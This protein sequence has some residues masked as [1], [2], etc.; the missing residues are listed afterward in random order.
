MSLWPFLVLT[1]SHRTMKKLRDGHI[2]VSGD[3]YPPFLYLPGSYREDNLLI[4]CFQGPILVAVSCSLFKNNVLFMR[5]DLAPHLPRSEISAQSNAWGSRNK[6]G[7]SKAPS[8]GACHTSIHCICGDACKSIVVVLIAFK[9]YLGL[10]VLI[11]IRW[12]ASL[13]WCIHDQRLL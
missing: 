11:P 10:L 5:L 8:D 12:L 3:D 1:Y 4:G 13:W 9:F 6:G 7:P 2:F